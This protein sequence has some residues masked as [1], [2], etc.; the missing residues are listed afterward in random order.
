MT[1]D[2]SDQ[3][4]SGNDS[5]KILTIDEADV[6]LK[7]ITLTNGRTGARGGVIHVEDGHLTLQDSVIKDS[8]AGDAGGGIYAS[9]SNVH[10]SGSE[11]K[12]NTA[13]RSGGGGLYFTSEGAAH[14]LHIEEWSVFSGN[15]AS[16]D[17]GAIRVAGGIVIIDKSSFSGNSADEGGMIEIWNGSLRVENTTIS[18][19]T[20][21]KAAASTPALIWI[22]AR[23][24]PWST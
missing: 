1:I 24:S 21:A 23:P 8:Q 3:T 11:I 19:T 20:R 18:T 2:G 5:A 10:I 4:V 7:D 22:M 6:T 12:D 15:K 16:Q 9:N 17:G 13:G 14:T